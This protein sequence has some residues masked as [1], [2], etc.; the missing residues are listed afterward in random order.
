MAAWNKKENE[1]GFWIVHGL[2]DKTKQVKDKG[3]ISLQCCVRT[4]SYIKVQLYN[5]VHTHSIDLLHI[6]EKS[7]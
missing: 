5:I 3:E 6:D 1:T 7:K 2:W 4:F